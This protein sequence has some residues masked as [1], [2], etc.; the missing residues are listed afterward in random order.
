MSE[1][2]R[3]NSCMYFI[4]KSPWYLLDLNGDFIVIEAYSYQLFYAIWKCWLLKEHIINFKWIF[5]LHS[6]AINLNRVNQLW[7]LN[8]YIIVG[9]SALK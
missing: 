6:T 2:E 8:I 3:E 7:L 9:A 1:A 4:E 5:K